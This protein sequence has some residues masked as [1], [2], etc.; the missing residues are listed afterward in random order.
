VP[1]VDGVVL[2]SL[3]GGEIAPSMA[4]RADTAQY[5]RALRTCR[6][7][8]IHRHGGASNRAG[9]R[10]IG[11]TAT[12]GENKR[13]VRYLHETPEDSVLIEAG[14]GYFR[15]YQG[16]AVV[17]VDPL[18]VDNWSAVVSY[19]I[20]D[21]VELTGTLY[22]AKA[23][24]LNQTPP[25]ATYW[26][27]LP[28][29]I[30]E[31]PTPFDEAGLFNWHQSGRIITFT[32]K[33]TGAYE[34]VYEAL[35]RWIFR[36]VDTSPRVD[37]PGSV[38][39]TGTAGTSE[40]G[41]VVTAVAPGDVEEESIASAAAIDATAAEPTT[42]APHVITWAAQSVDGVA[43]PQ[44]YVYCDPHGNGTYGFI[45]TTTGATEFR[46]PGIP[47]DF[48]ISPPLERTLFGDAEQF[49][50]VSA[51]YQQRRFFGHT[52][53]LPDA[54]Y[55][56]RVGLINNFTICSPLQDDDAITFRIAGNNHHPIRHMV[57][58]K[59][60]L[61]LLT[62]G[63]EWTAR[64]GEGRSLIPNGI[65]IEQETYVGSADMIRPVVVGNGI[66]YAQARG[67][68]VAEIK[69]DVGVEGLGGRDMTVYAGH[70]FDGY[71]L[72][73][74]DLML[75][76]DPIAWV[77]RNDGTLL[78]LTYIPELDVF[79]WH[80]HDTDGDFERVLVMPGDGVDEVYVIVRRVVDGAVVRYIEK[81][82]QRVIVTFNTD[83]F[84][85]DSGLSYSGAATSVVSGLTHLEGETVKVVADGT[86]RGEAVVTA[87]AVTLPSGAAATDIHVGLGYECDL[88]TLSLDAAGTS[89]R[90]KKKRVQ[91]IDL[92]IDESSR[93][94]KAGPDE[95][96]LKTYPIPT[97]AGTAKAHTGKVEMSLTSA[98]NDDG[99][100]FI[101]QDQPLP[102]SVLAIIPNVEVAG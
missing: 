52:P 86:Y 38:A 6:N 25:N 84:F 53:E 98:F 39:L 21:I 62:D 37:P 8:V 102:L 92:L 13:L 26:H 79:G 68:K 100:V 66:L 9:T 81:I 69:F 40:Y 59:H 1:A 90:G 95:D 78:G 54:A 15:F 99:R 74:M 45:G 31:I 24:S 89:V 14:V 73:D 61:C 30:L 50:H 64:G 83:A 29:D 18:D 51:T 60:G 101:R 93:V 67:S 2:R 97:Y 43:C 80:R 7:F 27:P 44:Y 76:P 57:A 55:G 5:Q 10:F 28:D 11:E 35:T 19:V 72:V 42:A 88:E 12:N 75:A 34:L 85:V 48:S 70:L 16:D 17:A 33:L 32:H 71:Q 41:Y 46:N 82:E 22:Y 36:E 65:Q 3:G 96:H 63:G 20:G 87:G 58:L 47:P 4:A 94:F 49:P 77:T 91:S 23:A 56:S